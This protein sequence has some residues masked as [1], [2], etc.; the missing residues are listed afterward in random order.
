MREGLAAV[1]NALPGGAEVFVA[2]NA[3]EALE[4]AEFH[5]PLDLVLLD[6]GL[7]DAEGC[8]LIQALRKGSDKKEIPELL[9]RLVVLRQ[10][11]TKEEREHYR[12]KVVEDDTQPK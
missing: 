12:Y 5:T 8:N 2:G 4:Q 1:I 9:K 6:F 10:E 7:P 11:A 3:V